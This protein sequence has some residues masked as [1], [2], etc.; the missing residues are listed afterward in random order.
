MDWEKLETYKR[1]WNKFK[2]NMT[3]YKMKM[4]Y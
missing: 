2:E 4:M 1:S 3:N